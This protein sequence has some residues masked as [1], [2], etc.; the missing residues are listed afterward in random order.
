MEDDGI[1]AGAG[2]APLSQARCRALQ[3]GECFGNFAQRDRI[4][5]RDALAITCDPPDAR[6]GADD[7]DA[8][9]D[10]RWGRCRAW[11]ADGRVRCS[12]GARALQ[13]TVSL[14]GM[15][16]VTLRRVAPRRVVA[17]AL[18]YRRSRARRLVVTLGGAGARY[19]CKRGRGDAKQ[20]SPAVSGRYAVDDRGNKRQT[21]G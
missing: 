18:V 1:A 5:E 20:R 9:L 10:R 7:L 17:L 21:E 16:G 2:G 14:V 4:D 12:D 3:S 13:P 15:G 19:V 11:T 6:R 8:R